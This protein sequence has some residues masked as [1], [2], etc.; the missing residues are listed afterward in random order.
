M[1]TPGRYGGHGRLSTLKIACRS[2]GQGI[3]AMMLVN[4]GEAE[5]F[6]GSL[7]RRFTRVL[8]METVQLGALSSASHTQSPYH[9]FHHTPGWNHRNGLA[10]S[11]VL[12]HRRG[13]TRMRN[14]GYILAGIFRRMIGKRAPVGV[15]IFDF[16]PVR[17][18]RH[19]WSSLLSM[20]LIPA[21][22]PSKPL[23]L[24]PLL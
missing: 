4:V 15:F 19:V 22:H 21:V 11:F 17:S 9:H 20:E 16:K 12:T 8:Q 1:G 23:L 6:V 14:L 24:S 5:S 18:V 7:H 10:S 3:T 13:L 2:S